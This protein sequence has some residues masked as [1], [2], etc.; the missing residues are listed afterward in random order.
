MIFDEPGLEDLALPVPC[1]ELKAVDSDLQPSLSYLLKLSVQLNWTALV[2]ERR[3][4]ENQTVL[5]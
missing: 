4:L 1:L 5:L 2:H 3:Q